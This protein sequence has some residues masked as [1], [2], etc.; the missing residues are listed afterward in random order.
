MDELH[1]GRDAVERAAVVVAGDDGSRRF[2]REQV[3]FGRLGHRGSAPRNR[4]GDDSGRGLAHDDR[5]PTR[6]RD[7]DRHGNRDTELV[8]DELGQQ[9][10]R[11]LGACVARWHDDRRFGQEQPRARNTRLAGDRPEG[12]RGRRGRKVDSGR[13]H[14]DERDH[15][16]RRENVSHG[17]SSLLRSAYRWRISNGTSWRTV[18][19]TTA[20][21]TSK[22]TTY[23]PGA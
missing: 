14:P 18:W 12:K 10:P 22:R 3:A 9:A 21:V 4:R 6:G 15:R 1:E 17:C 19:L 7:A 13:G 16:E 8:G 23:A 20:S 11:V 5:G 2:D